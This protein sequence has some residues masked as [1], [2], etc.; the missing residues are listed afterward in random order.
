MGTFFTPIEQMQ[1]TGIDSGAKTEKKVT[2]GSFEDLL[3][4]AMQEYQTLNEAAAQDSANLALGSA[5]DLAGA[6]ITAMKAESM[7][8]TTVQL[9]TRAVNAYKEIMQM[10][11]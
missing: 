2:G 3:T 10:S 6:Q 4:G 9:T 11:V 1:F 5:D 7:L 8:Q